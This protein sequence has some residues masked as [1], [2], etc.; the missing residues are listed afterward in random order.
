VFDEGICDEPAAYVDGHIYDYYSD[1]QYYSYCGIYTCGICADSFCA[2]EFADACADECNGGGAC[3]SGNFSGWC[4]GCDSSWEEQYCNENTGGSCAWYPGDEGGGS[5]GDA[6]LSNDNPPD[7]ILDCD[8]FGIEPD[9]EGFCEWFNGLGGF[10]AGCLNDCDATDLEVINNVIG[11]A[12]V[13]EQGGPGPS[14]CLGNCSEIAES[15]EPTTLDGWSEACA[16]IL[17]C[18]ENGVFE[19]SHGRNNRQIH[20]F[21]HSSKL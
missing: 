14:G 16:I 20:H 11:G 6:E 3:D 2:S 15:P 1:D 8:G 21:L 18:G 9:D 17:N 13:S 4:M 12:C 10:D 5:C 19:D 7:C